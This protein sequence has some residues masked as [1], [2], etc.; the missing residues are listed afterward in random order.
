MG[1]IKSCIEVIHNG[2]VNIVEP[3]LYKTKLVKQNFI[4]MNFVTKD[5]VPKL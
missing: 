4:I 2:N 1:N 3:N 5:E